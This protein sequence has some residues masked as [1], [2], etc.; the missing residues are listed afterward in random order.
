VS[1]REAFGHVCARVCR[2][3]GWELVPDGIRVSWANGR[4][5]LVGLEFFEFRDQELVR[6]HTTIGRVGSLGP[7]RLVAALR[8]NA[9]LAHGALA[10]MV[11][12]LVMTDTLMLRDA[13]ADEIRACVAY[14]AQTAD[15]YEKSLFGTDEH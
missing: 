15:S 11:D 14:L 2:E 6:L 4:H 5:Q 3:E 10:V 1:T 9:G 13:D 7:E 12:E 8:V